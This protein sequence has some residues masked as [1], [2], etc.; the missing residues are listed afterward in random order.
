[1]DLSKTIIQQKKINHYFSK[2]SS[3]ETNQAIVPKLAV[4]E[5]KIDYADNFIKADRLKKKVVLLQSMDQ[6]EETV[7]KKINQKIDKL[8]FETSRFKQTFYWNSFLNRNEL[9]SK[10]ICHLSKFKRFNS[11]K[12]VLQN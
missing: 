6:I 4:K 9:K 8:Y 10:R 3:I 2:I 7:L 12:K 5:E 1:M 11:F